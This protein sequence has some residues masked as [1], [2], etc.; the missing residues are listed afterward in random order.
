MLDHQITSFYIKYRF[1]GVICTFVNFIKINIE[2]WDQNFVKRLN[3]IFLEAEVGMIT[4]C[5]AF[6][7]LSRQL[8]QYLFDRCESSFSAGVFSAF[9]LVDFEALNYFHNG[10]W[11]SFA[12]FKEL[13]S[14]VFRMSKYPRKYSSDWNSHPELNFKLFDHFTVPNDSLERIF[15]KICGH[16]LFCACSV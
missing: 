10:S 3:S 14:E 6:F 15:Y 4:S 1:F 8:F 5:F 7:T 2:F 12:S 9:W 16:T 11:N 13:P